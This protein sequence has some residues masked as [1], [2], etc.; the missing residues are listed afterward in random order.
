MPWV[1]VGACVWLRVLCLCCVYVRLCEARN[2]EFIIGGYFLFVAGKLHVVY[3][4]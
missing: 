4:V 1:C 3:K 2:T